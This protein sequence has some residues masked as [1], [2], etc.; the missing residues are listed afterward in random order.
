MNTKFEITIP[1]Q[2]K[3]LNLDRDGM[4][5]CTDE[6]NHAMSCSDMWCDTNNMCPVIKCHFQHYR[7]ADKNRNIGHVSSNC[8]MCKVFEVYMSQ[9]IVNCN[10]L[11][12]KIKYCK[13]YK[14]IS[15]LRGCSG[16]F[17]GQSNS[18]GGR[19]NVAIKISDK[20]EDI[21]SNGDYLEAKD[22]SSKSVDA[23]EGAETT[24]DASALKKRKL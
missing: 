20:K 1:K 18:I 23:I 15:P 11:S 12:C 5:Y 22:N 19:Q 13:N 4:V 2:M 24:D 8:K 7:M 10:N 6:F 17:G 14:N 9:H 3:V 21:S 16:I